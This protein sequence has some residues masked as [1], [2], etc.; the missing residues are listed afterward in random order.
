M[1]YFSYRTLIFV[2]IGFLVVG[3]GKNVS[4]TQEADAIYFGGAIL[5]MDGDIPQYA[6][7]VLVKDGRILFVGKL[8]EADNIATAKHRIDLAGRTMLPGFI[9]AHGHIFNTG[10]QKLSA[11]LLPPPDGEGADVASL[12]SLLN[13]WKGENSASIEKLG[14]IVGFGYDD[15]QLQEK[16]HPT[17][18]ELDAVSTELPVV[19]IHQS[20]HLATMNHKG[21]ELAGFTADSKDP[22]G[23][24]IRREEDGVTPNGVLEEM[25]F[26]GPIFKILGTLDADANKQV[27]L[28]GVDA[29]KEFG[30]TTAQ[31]GRASKDAALTWQALANEN[32]L[33]IDVAVYP[34][35]QAETAYME[36]V[37]TESAYNNHFRIAG[38]KLSFD[39]SPQGKTAWLSE[40]YLVPPS[41]M[42]NSYSGYPAIPEASERQ[43]LVDMAFKNDWQL[44]THC[45]G[46]AA[47]D[48]LIEAVAEAQDKFG[49]GDRRTVMVHSQTVRED[50]LDRMQEL[51]IVPSFFS[52]HT[53]YWG[54][55]HRDETLGKERAYHISPTE[56]ALRRGMKFTEHHDAP[57]A[58]PSAIMIIHTTVNRTSRS[59]DVIGA[60]QRVTPYIALKAVTE[61]AAWQYFE[62]DSKGSLVKGKLADFVILD[63]NPLTVNPQSIMD[64]KVLQT[65][66]EGKTVYEAL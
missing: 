26:F 37:G 22:A 65:I 44:L 36:E 21:L 39:G 15:S 40:P 10:I 41:G 50:Q 2:A 17:A 66:K 13:K 64:I 20:G 55:W 43:S 35:L 61:W 46:D 33:M 56:S 57:V 16:R 31:E 3:C 52:M 63:N 42:D 14:W 47:S 59:G 54:D 53:Y 58:L 24:V 27:A 29:Y 34:D 60:D 18:S 4:K 28:A 51:M 11:N 8:S 38:V 12:I 6:E 19:I 7:A 62:E 5:T 1:R 25:A 32:K 9:D 23:G 30:F 48:A 49:K 45:N